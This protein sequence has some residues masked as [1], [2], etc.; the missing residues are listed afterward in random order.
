MDLINNVVDLNNFLSKHKSKS[1]GFVPTM[2]ALHLGHLSL[3]DFA[4]S[5]SDIV[6][7][8]IYINPTQFND[9]NDFLKYPQTIEEDIK[10]LHAK[11]VDALFLPSQSV[12]YPNGV[13]NL[14]FYNLNDIDIILE[15]AYRPGHFQGV[16][17]V[18]NRFIELLYPNFIFLG[19]K[20]FQQVIV[21][22]TL[23]Q[24]YFHDKNV[25]IVKCPT[26]RNENGLALSSRNKRLS[27]NGLLTASLISK[28]VSNSILQIDFIKISPKEIEADFKL[29]LLKN[30]FEKIDYVCFANP[31]NFKQLNQWEKDARLFIA[32][33][34]ENVRL[35]DNFKIL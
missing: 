22:E 8:S 20:D 24:N 21:I 17:A 33:Y 1:I 3:I 6:I 25:N 2:G 30:G 14:P 10:M 11:N 13:D 19:E 34:L 16:A 32:V 18:L 12:M 28:Y 27:E 29:Y 7:A 15:G 35:I 31:Y 9:K 23:V 26:I 4:R 5:Q